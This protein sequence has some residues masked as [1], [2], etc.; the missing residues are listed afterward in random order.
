MSLHSSFKSGVIAFILFSSTWAKCLGGPVEASYRANFAI[1]ESGKK[2][3][4][5]PDGTGTGEWSVGFGSWT[6]PK[7][8]F[9]FAVYDPILLSGVGGYS[10]AEDDGGYFGNDE[11]RVF[12][13]GKPDARSAI[14][15]WRSAFRAQVVVEGAIFKVCSGSGGN[16][17]DYYLYH[18]EALIWSQE[19]VSKNGMLPI[20]GVPVLAMEAG[21]ELLFV[22]RAKKRNNI[23]DQAY[24]SQEA[25]F[26][27]SGTAEN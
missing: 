13:P 1:P 12:C 10:Q 15:R 18:N 19:E 6:A 16:G 5:W 2:N 11:K 22:V 21:D 27:I 25:D 23:C 17:V 4:S 9:R 20:K 3:G 7:A 26:R 14:I 8:G 24:F